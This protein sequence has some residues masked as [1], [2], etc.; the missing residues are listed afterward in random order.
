MLNGFISFGIHFFFGK[1]YNIYEYLV[2]NRARMY[3]SILELSL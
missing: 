2:Y 3:V 1:N